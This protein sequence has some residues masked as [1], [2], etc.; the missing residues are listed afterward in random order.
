MDSHAKIRKILNMPD[1]KEEWFRWYGVTERRK[2]SLLK[3]PSH[4]NSF[5]NPNSESTL[6]LFMLG[7]LD[8]WK[9]FSMETE[10]PRDKSS[11]W[12]SSF[13][14][15]TLKEQEMD[16]KLRGSD[17]CWKNTILPDVLNIDDHKLEKNILLFELELYNDAIHLNSEKSKENISF[18]E[19]EDIN[20]WVRY[21]A[22]MITPGEK[23]IIFFE[24]KLQSD[25]S[26]SSKNYDYLDQMMKGLEGAHLLTEK[27]ESPYSEWNFEYVLICP[28][29][30]DDYGL[31]RYS[32]KQEEIGKSLRKYNDLLNSRYSDSINERC[33]PEHF[34]DFIKKVPKRIHKLYWKDLGDAL[35][36]NDSNFFIN[37]F[38]QL[39]DADFPKERVKGIRKKFR[40]AGIRVNKTDNY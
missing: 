40:E 30:L 19:L 36:E 28:K 1:A 12:N 3:K 32:K 8:R 39:E 24:S 20:K 13:F 18:L 11:R 22:I 33:Y 5:F 31:T 23:K 16:K 34:A 25:L 21:D 14:E 2:D 26:Y 27:K 29:L 4:P 15:Q 6:T 17:N 35:L 7:N 9:Q 37:Y 10:P 38:T